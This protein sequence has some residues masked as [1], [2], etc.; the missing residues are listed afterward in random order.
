MER[1]KLMKRRV[2]SSLEEVGLNVT[3]DE[4]QELIQRCAHV[5]TLGTSRSY[6][7]SLKALERAVPEKIMEE[8][9]GLEPALKDAKLLFHQGVP[10]FPVG[11]AVLY[12][13][14]L[15]IISPIV[16]SAI[17]FNLPAFIA[18]WYAGRKFPDGRN[19]VSLWKILVGVPAFALWGALVIVALLLLGKFLWLAA[20]LALTSLGLKLY[21]RFKKLAVAVH[22]AL[23][24]PS[25][26]SRMLKFH[27]TVVQS[28][29][30]ETV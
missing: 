6:F 23:R 5:A 25:L 28:V 14:V 26:R 21:Y 3:S 7:K 11:P 10:L 18:G 27:Q 30:N 4:D 20:Y 19:V 22:N 29:P 13:V 2:Q 9:R 15:L 16:L 1:L 12:C 17:A 24:Q 8:W